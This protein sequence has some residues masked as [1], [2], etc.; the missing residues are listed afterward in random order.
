MDLFVKRINTLPGRGSELHNMW[1]KP[2]PHKSGMSWTCIQ[3]DEYFEIYKK[4]MGFSM[5]KSESPF[6]LVIRSDPPRMVA[7]AATQE[8]IMRDF[9]SAERI[10]NNAMLENESIAS[11]NIAE[12]IDFLLVRLQCMT[13]ELLNSNEKKV[14]Q[15]EE[16]RQKEEL[17]SA[18]AFR[19]TFD[20]KTEKLLATFACSMWEKVPKSGTL[21]LSHNYLCFS[22]PISTRLVKLL[23]VEIKS[24]SKTKHNGVGTIK[25]VGPTE[26]LWLVSF[27]LNDIFD[28]LQQLWDLA[29]NRVLQSAEKTMEGIEAT[30]SR[31]ISTTKSAETPLSPRPVPQKFNSKAS[32]QQNKRDA[33]FQ[34]NFRLPLDETLLKEYTKVRVL[35]GTKFRKGRLYISTHFIAFESNTWG[36]NKFFS[37]V[38]AFQDIEFISTSE[39]DPFVLGEADLS[40][41][42]RSSQVIKLHEA[43]G[44][45]SIQVPDDNQR[46]AL[47][48]ELN[49]LH[50]KIKSQYNEK[51]LVNSWSVW[52]LSIEDKIGQSLLENRREFAPMYVEKEERKSEDWRKYCAKYGNGLSMTKTDK[53][54]LMIRQGIPNNIRGRMWMI[55]SGA[56]ALLLSKGAGYFQSL[57]DRRDECQV[58][59]E[60]EK[61]L[62]R[63]FPEHPFFQTEEGLNCL[64]KVLVAFSVHNPVIGYCQSMNIV[65]ATLLL[66]LPEEH[67]FFLLC[68]ICEQLVPDYY[69]KAMI[70]S[71]VD[72][73]LFQEL[74]T[75]GMPEVAAHLEST[76]LP[77]PLVTLPWFMCI[78]IGYVP[79]EVALRILDCFFGMDG[80]PFL[81]SVGL[82]LFEA[83]EEAVLNEND[84]TLLSNLLRNSVKDPDD[85]LPLAF[86][87]ADLIT[88]SMLADM[89]N[90]H[91]AK[92][93]KDMETKTENTRLRE[94]KKS[95]NLSPA[96]VTRLYNEFVS[97]NR[98]TQA[99]YVQFE[100]LFQKHCPEWDG[101]IEIQILFKLLDKDRTGLIDVGDY[102]SALSIIL[103]G[104]PAERIHY[105]YEYAVTLLQRFYEKKPTKEEKEE[106]VEKK[107]K[108]KE[109]DLISFDDDHDDHADEDTATPPKQSP[110]SPDGLWRSRSIDVPAIT[111][112]FH[113]SDLD[114]DN[115]LSFK[116][117]QAA[118]HHPILQP[119]LNLP[120]K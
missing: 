42:Q 57:Y 89:K 70:G 112:S 8:I 94:L 85:I 35:K 110:R 106:T 83:N 103:A 5:L 9:Q 44:E 52:S 102:V 13:V 28:M 4:R 76:G 41:S 38:M 58:K 12:R 118:L 69:V 15:E 90:T 77:L 49:D 105:E 72:Q 60:I 25:I 75:N 67:S 84:G 65:C 116:E 29:M 33:N 20:L 26:E 31:R 45:Y 50:Y 51:K 80:P 99:D 78:F 63:S 61:D 22:S 88:P 47:L 14:Q 59:D 101:D 17:T 18:D 66:F 46:D 71:I 104:T 62:H 114:E 120:E 36:N 108:K 34:Q 113:Q 37:F 48:S 79:L 96:D 115:R 68:T 117:Y 30:Y 32:L 53:L 91:R 87:E 24:I 56:F 95:V 92:A 27:R 10:L 11:L 97:A 111:V 43:V 54:K 16:Q 39:D 100:E 81:F 6:R 109:V 3:Q 2:E 64:R 82:A 74:M 55:F 19:N 23:L 86:E 21:Y 73:R 40:R 119:V 1:V 93:I 107:E 98:G 7:E